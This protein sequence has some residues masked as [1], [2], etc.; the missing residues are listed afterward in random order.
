MIREANIN[1]AKVLDNLLS[2]LIQ[3]ER[4]YDDS[5]SPFLI[6]LDYYKNY[7]SKKGHLFYVYEINNEIVGY[8]YAKIKNDGTQ[9]RESA[10]IDALY[11]KEEYRHQQV[12]TKLLE[13]TINDIK[14]ISINDIE[15]S[16]MSANTDAKNLYE[17]FGFYTYKETMKLK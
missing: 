17:K 9:V 13:K 8:I 11:V 7:I 1:D 3:D 16:V 10:I 5:I 4:K 14:S 2:L 12:A 6:I 15:I